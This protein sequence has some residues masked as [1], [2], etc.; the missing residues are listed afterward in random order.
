M[1]LGICEKCQKCDN[2]ITRNDLK[3]II[4]INGVYCTV[5]EWCYTIFRDRN[6]P[7]L[8]KEIINNE[9]TSNKITQ[10]NWNLGRY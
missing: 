6:I 3:Y 7:N 4:N 9:T 2:R 5:C 10:S 8:N 1:D